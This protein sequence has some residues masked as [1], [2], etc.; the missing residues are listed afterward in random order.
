MWGGAG[1]PQIDDKL[2]R[3]ISLVGAERQPSGRV[4]GVTVDH[5]DCRLA[6]S[7]ATR[8]GHIHLDDKAIAVFHQSMTD[9]A[10]CCPGA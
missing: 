3:V 6:S 8:A 4:R 2:C 7:T 9:E 10:Q 5:I 1:L